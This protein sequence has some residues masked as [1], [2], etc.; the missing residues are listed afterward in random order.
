MLLKLKRFWVSFFQNL[1]CLVFFEFINFR[2]GRDFINMRG[3]LIQG[4]DY[5]YIYIYIYRERERLRCSCIHVFSMSCVVCLLYIYI[6]M[7][8]EGEMYTYLSLYIYIYIYIVRT[9]RMLRKL[10]TSPT[11]RRSCVP[12]TKIVYH[13]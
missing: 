5:I 11:S 12:S 10:R 1:G 8:R 13:V 9:S 7:Y 6:C 3:L 2:P 4:G